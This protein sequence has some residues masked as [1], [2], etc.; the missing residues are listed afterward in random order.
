VLVKLTPNISDI[1]V[2]GRAAARAKADG[3]SL[4]NTI[5]S[6][7]GVDLERL[8]PR[9]VVGKQST[10]GGYCGPAVKPIALHMVA[11][12]AQDPAVRLPISGIGGVSNWQDAAEFMALGASSVQVC[13]AVMHYGFRIVEDMI[14]GLTQYLTDR[15]M[16]SAMELVGAAVPAFT[17]WGA[18]DLNHKVIANIDPNKCIGCD[19][20]H[21]ACRDGSH[22]CI[23]FHPDGSPA[24]EAQAD[25]IKTRKGAPPVGRIPYVAEDECT[26]CNLCSLVCPVD[27]CITM[28]DVT[29][30][31]TPETWNQ[32]VERAGGSLAAVAASPKMWKEKH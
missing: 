10:N 2:P 15:G 16:T 6:I 30:N 27:N 14:D 9:P 20:C 8:V 7:M 32:R 11:Q 12:L 22:D 31:S 25:R 1:R 17:D 3:I 5:K 24:L 26:G 19:L 29:K 4:I 13:T 18:L 23:H 21:V 28:L